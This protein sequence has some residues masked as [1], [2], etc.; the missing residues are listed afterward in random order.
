MKALKIVGA[1]FVAVLLSFSFVACSSDDD[2]NDPGFLELTSVIV[3]T[4]AQDGD[5][6]ILVINANGT[7][8]WYDNEESYKQ[9]E[10]DVDYT[11][12]WTC[13]N[14]WLYLTTTYHSDGSEQTHTNT[15][16]AT[17][18]SKDKIVWKDYYDD[19]ES[20][21]GEDGRDAFGYYRFWTWER[22]NK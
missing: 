10:V 15:M 2:E 3:G 5:D 17:D 9:K 18:I 12:T 19:N 6:D 7:G 4:W 8:Q 22:Y 20:G 11:T 21:N 1:V 13:K 16:R 14:G